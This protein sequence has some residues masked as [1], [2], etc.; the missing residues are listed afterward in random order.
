MDA[1][2]YWRLIPQ[3]L[4][5][6]YHSKSQLLHPRRASNRMGA[7]KL[8]LGVPTVNL[9]SSKSH[10]CDSPAVPYHP[11]RCGVTQTASLETRSSSETRLVNGIRGWTPR[12]GLFRTE[13]PPRGRPHLEG[14]A[15]RDQIPVSPDG[16][17]RSA[18]SAT[19][20]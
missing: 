6:Q 20:P 9:I 5:P 18:I 10:H 3:P 13:V 12:Q 19:D 8:S 14:A 16:G 4:S 1:D 17:C 7:P 2:I 15:G 11:G